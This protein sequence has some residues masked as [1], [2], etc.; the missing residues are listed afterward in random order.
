M[1]LGFSAG[2]DLQNVFAV[3]PLLTVL[4]FAPVGHKALEAFRAFHCQE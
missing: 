2:V 1:G 3:D 4:D